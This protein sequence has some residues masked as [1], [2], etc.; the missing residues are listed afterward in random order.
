MKN[1]KL[2]AALKKVNQ[3]AE[4]NNE[5]ANNIDFVNKDMANSLRGGAVVATTKGGCS[6]NGTFSCGWY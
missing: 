5:Q 4:N 2:I 6:C 3:E 1:E